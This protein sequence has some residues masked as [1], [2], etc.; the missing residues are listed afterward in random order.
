MWY[1][2]AH[3]LNTSPRKFSLYT[4]VDKC[5]QA[6]LNIFNEYFSKEKIKILSIV[7]DILKGL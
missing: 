5:M 1:S 7:G 6:I 3:I 2:H 4:T